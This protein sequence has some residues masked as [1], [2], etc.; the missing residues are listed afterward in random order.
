MAKT[1]TTKPRLKP[2]AKA[3]SR[4]G[5][6]TELGGVPGG[7]GAKRN[8]LMVGGGLLF[9]VLAMFTGA[10]LVNARGTRKAVVVSAM[11]I[12]AGARISREMLRIDHIEAD[13]SLRG[14]PGSEASSLVGKVA[15]QRIPAGVL[16]VSEEVG[17]A[18]EPPAGFVLLAMTLEPGELPV[19]SL[20][21]GDRVDV[22]RTPGQITG[23]DLGG[24]IATASVW[25]MWGSGSAQTVT[26]G[27]KRALTLAVPD[28]DAVA[29]TQ[30]ASRREIRL[31]AR[32]GGP[33]WAP[34]AAPIAADGSLFP[35]L[36]DRATA[37]AL[38][39]VST[40]VAG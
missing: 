16:I 29:V 3:A 11:E 34:V 20:T 30:A 22:V 25:S 19:A 7:G 9:A 18:L 14:L 37:K 21:Y 10:L 6:V 40:T 31:I 33:V 32:G 1:G 5:D 28:A 4:M 12:P 13:S 27:S 17:S 8:P 36:S 2:E 35:V 26:A 38:P 39:V 23:D 24:V 15:R